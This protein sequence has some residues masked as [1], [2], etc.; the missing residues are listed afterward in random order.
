MS[1]TARLRDIQQQ[2]NTIAASVGR[3]PEDIQLIGVTKGQPASIIAEAYHAGLHDFAENY[4]QEAK[5]KIEALST[6]DICWHFIGPIQSNKTAAIAAHFTW[7]HSVCRNKI[8]DLLA[9]HRPDHLAPLNVCIQ[10]NLDDEASKS[11][12]SSTEV[13]H[14]AEHLQS[15]PRLKL[16]GLMAIPEPRYNET[17]QYESLY[18][19]TALLQQL[20]N[21]L[22]E[23]LDTLS[24]GMSGDYAAAIRAGSSMIRIGEA[25]FGPRTMPPT[26]T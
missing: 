16:R 11:G 10:V 19:L 18:R 22:T 6:L 4:W 8:A 2:I 23:P 5:T 1:V 9:Q 21:T 3:H 26:T 14:L 20:N 13:L 15:L 24:I 17:E 12:V 25:L 7:V